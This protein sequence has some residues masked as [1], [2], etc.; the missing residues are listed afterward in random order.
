MEVSVPDVR[1][2][3]GYVPENFISKS[4]YYG[5]I[6]RFCASPQ[7]YAIGLY[8]SSNGE[9]GKVHVTAAVVSSALRPS[10]PNNWRDS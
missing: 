9:S 10:F 2:R 4:L 5:N 3:I 8:R 7:L 1:R 6:A